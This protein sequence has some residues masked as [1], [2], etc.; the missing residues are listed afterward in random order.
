LSHLVDN[1]NSVGLTSGEIG[2]RYLL[3]ALTDNG[4][5]DV[6]YTLH[7]GTTGPGY[8]DILS[9][10]ATALTEAWDAN[11]EDSQDHFMLGHITEW[12]YHDLAGIQLDPSAPG[13]QHVIIKPAF[14]SGLASAYASYASVR[15]NIL[16]SWTLSNNQ[17]TLNVIIPVGA[18]GSV[19]LPILGNISPGLKVQESGTTIWQNSAA[20][21]G[22]TGVAYV[23]VQG[24]GAQTLQVWKVGSGSYQ[25]TWNVLQAPTGLVATG[26]N[27]KVTLSWNS[28]ATATGYNVKRSTTSGT[29]YVTVG[30]GVTST[31][32]TDHA[33]TNNT[34]YYYVVS[35]LYGT[36]ESANSSES[37]ATPGFLVNPGFETP[38]VGAAAF[39]YSP[40]GSGWTFSA[41]SGAN[42]AGIT[43]N[44]SA[45]NSG[46]PNAPQGVQ[47]AFLQGSGSISQTFTGLASGA[48]YQVSFYAAQRNN[49]YGQQLGQT[50]QVLVDGAVVGTFA[51]PEADQSYALYTANF[52]A[53]AS[54]SHTLEFLGTDTNGG[55][56]T[57]FIDSV[58]V[59]QVPPQLLVNPGFETPSV[60]AAAFAYSP[61]GSGWTFGAQSGG[62]GAG[63]AANGSAFNSGNPN[64][65]QGVQVAFLQGLGTISQTFTGLVSGASYQVSFYAAQRNNIYGQ[66]LGQTWEVLVD[67]AVVGSFA[68]PEADQ[69]YAQ[70][71]ANFTATAS[72]SHTLEFLGT[73]AN[74]GDNTIFIDS[75]SLS[76]LSAKA[77]ALALGI[78]APVVKPPA[79]LAAQATAGRLSIV[80]PADHLGWQLQAQTSSLAGGLGTNWVTIPGSELS[81]QFNGTVDSGLGSKCVLFRL[82]PSGN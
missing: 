41:E 34:T 54:A 38:S 48:S 77:Q 67:G 6:V 73:D 19:Y 82:V 37:A 64:A 78:A 10:G 61:A 4:R 79:V 65:P 59:A 20:T 68:P 44:G 49:I 15:G 70:Y 74:G 53:T 33:V 80:W 11:P 43:A 17:A 21:S 22:A 57:V 24:T 62:N 76:Q 51:P 18:T 69:S 12:F 46:N 1:V 29:G 26:G 81:T 3:R 5:P 35:A 7:S 75:V 9:K 66:Q 27:G 60:G 16:S 63:I 55:D 30:A 40:A 56:N 71:T 31:S 45:F 23:G 32:Y 50:W 72:A 14:V 39:E 28:A 8:G 13:F 58:A 42:G 25:F 2:H 52:T 36:N 47:V